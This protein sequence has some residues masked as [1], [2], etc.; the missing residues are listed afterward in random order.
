MQDINRPYAPDEETADFLYQTY[1]LLRTAPPSISKWAQQLS[2]ESIASCPDSWRV[3]GISERAL[4]KIAA[5]GGKTTQQRGHWF[6]REQRYGAL[7]GEQTEVMERDA[8]I[9]FFFEHDTTV[10]IAKE[11]NNKGGDHT[12]WGKIIPVPEGYFPL[13]GYSFSVRKGK[14][15][16]WIRDQVAELDAHMVARAMASPRNYTA[17]Q[18]Q[19]LSGMSADELNSAVSSKAFYCL[20]DGASEPLYPVWQ[21]GVEKERRMRVLSEFDSTDGLQWAMH[22][23]LIK[24][25]DD[26]DELSP[27]RALANEEFDIERIISSLKHQLGQNKG[28]A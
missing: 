3:I 1:L 16:P 13:S 6:A 23:Y 24:K 19:R 27:S 20:V 7:F 18:I 15:M 14:E 9:R 25:H 26:L 28:V 17:E 2:L 21:L 12:T 11:Q 10:I 4:R 5:D 8:F 22:F